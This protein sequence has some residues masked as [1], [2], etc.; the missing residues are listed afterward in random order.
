MVVVIPAQAVHVQR[1]AR[2][3]RK[4]LQAVRDHLGAEIPDLLALEPEIDH[5]VGAVRQ[6]D[7]RPAEG[8]VEWRIG[9]SEASEARGRAER[10][11][12]GIPERDADIFC[13]VVVVD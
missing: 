8:L 3:L 11:R 5:A 12:E 13:G 9:R 2:R 1:H 7:N 10:A 6:I 4:A